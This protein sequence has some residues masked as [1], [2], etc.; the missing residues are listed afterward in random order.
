MMQKHDWR[1]SNKESV[2]ELWLGFLRFFTEEFNCKTQVVCIRQHKP[3]TRFEKMWTN[4]ARGFAIEDPF[5]LDHN[6]GSGVSRKS[7][8][9]AITHMEYFQGFKDAFSCAKDSGKKAVTA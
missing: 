8:L 5:D 7:K 6:L 3:L 1:C 4:S 2:G 9:S